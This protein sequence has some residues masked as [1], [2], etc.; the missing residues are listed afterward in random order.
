ML[1]AIAIDDEP[2]ALEI[3]RLLAQ[4]IPFLRLEATFTDALEALAFLP[5]HPID[6]VLLDIK[7]PDISGLDWLRGLPHPPLVIFTTA[8]SEY[9]AESY[10]L[11][12]VDYLVKPIGF[13]RLLKALNRAAR[14]RETQRPDY[15]FVKSGHEYHR[16]DFAQVRFVQSD[17]NYVDFYLD[18]QRLTVRMTLGE[19]QELLPSQFMQVHRGYVV[20]LDRIDQV[21]HNHLIMGEDRIPIGPSYREALRRKLGG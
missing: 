3:I 9:A 17:T 8:Y 10:E 7:M 5:Q 4:R 15:A 16:I 14:L 19:V 13:N 2:A 12:A 18:H 1:T 21:V 6:L 20:N 11:E